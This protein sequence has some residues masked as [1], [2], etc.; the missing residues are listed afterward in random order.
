VLDKDKHG[1]SPLHRASKL[2]QQH[3]GTQWRTEVECLEHRVGISIR[4]EEN[5]RGT[6]V[7]NL[8]HVTV[9]LC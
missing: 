3:T 2:R 6:E 4:T 5:G 8:S 9:A 1:S 7:P